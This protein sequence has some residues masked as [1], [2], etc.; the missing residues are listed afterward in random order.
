VTGVNSQEE[1]AALELHLTG[2]SGV[3]A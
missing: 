1:L 3:Y 2:K